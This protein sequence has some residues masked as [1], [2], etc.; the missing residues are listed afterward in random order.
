MDLEGV[1]RDLYAL[2]PQEF[3]AARN[4]RAAQARASGERPLADEVRR[5]RRPSAGAWVLN[6]LARERP[7]DVGAVVELG[8][9]LREAMGVLGADE[10]RALDRQRRD[11]TRA[12]AA[13][14]AALA[15]DEGQRVPAATLAAVEESLRSGM[16]DEGAGAALLTGLVVETF[17]STGLDPVDL[18]TVL[19]VPGAVPPR[20]SAVSGSDASAG[21]GGSRAPSDDPAA[22]HRAVVAAARAE[23]GAARDARAAAEDEAAAAARAA[24]RTR[25]ARLELEARRDELARALRATDTALATAVAEEAAAEGAVEAAA[26]AVERARAAEAEARAAVD[27]AL[28]P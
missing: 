18:T 7:E 21:S 13:S 22:A 26:G 8:A 5:L 10:L 27:T 6:L 1:A 19:A 16:V 2:A 24:T 15:R 3:T 12:V 17:S 25:T 9:R 4:E 20:L 14:G 28:S 11:L 23:L